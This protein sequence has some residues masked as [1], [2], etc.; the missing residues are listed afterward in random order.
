MKNSDSDVSSDSSPLSSPSLEGDFGDGS[1]LITA[2]CRSGSVRPR[3]SSALASRY[4]SIV[5]WKSRWSDVRFVNTAT[6]KSTHST[7]P[8]ASAWLE[9]SIAVAVAPLSN[10]PAISCWHCNASGV[11]L[12]TSYLPL[13]GASHPGAV[14][15]RFSVGSSSSGSHTP[16]CGVSLVSSSTYPVVPITPHLLSLASRIERTKNVVVVLPFVPVIPTVTNEALGL[17]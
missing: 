5:P 14:H 3:N 1:R 11:V 4:A 9:T 8:C 13:Y 15:S 12:G 16:P 2:L 6:S 17:P 7:R 10:M